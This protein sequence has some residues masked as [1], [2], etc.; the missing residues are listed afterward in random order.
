MI[1]QQDTL[2]SNWNL[3][4]KRTLAFLCRITIYVNLIFAQWQW[5]HGYADTNDIF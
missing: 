4:L 2:E 3:K 1:Y 5:L